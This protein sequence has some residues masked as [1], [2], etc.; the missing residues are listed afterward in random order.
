MNIT[1]ILLADHNIHLYAQ[2][3]KLYEQEKFSEAI[4]I[5]ENIIDNGYESWEIYY[6]L[7]NSYY[8]DRQLGKAILNYERAN[9]LNSENE[10]IIFNLELANLMVADKINTPPDFLFFKIFSNIKNLF[11]LN[12]LTYIVI[13]SYLLFSLLLIFYILNK[14]RIVQKLSIVILVPIIIILVA[15]TSILGVRI[16]EHNTLNFGIIIAEK[17]NVMGSPGENGTEIFS[18]HEG[19]KVQVQKHNHNWLQIRLIDGKV[20]WIKKDILEII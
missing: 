18:L 19:V 3:N 20:G 6:N 14:K 8:K 12:V 1:P 4:S 15:F 10:D 9:A 11:S 17:I 7:G 5:Y 2:A 16:Y 13:I